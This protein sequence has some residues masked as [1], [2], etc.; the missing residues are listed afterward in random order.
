M[1]YEVITVYVDGPGIHGFGLRE[2]LLNVVDGTG[3]EKQGLPVRAGGGGPLHEGGYGIGV[4]A[5]LL[6]AQPQIYEGLGSYNF[7]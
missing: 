1:L 5:G 6:V 7:V 4:F 2:E 3:I